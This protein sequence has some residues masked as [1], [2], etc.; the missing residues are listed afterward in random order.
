MQ[1]YCSFF[2]FLWHFFKQQFVFEYTLYMNYSKI[3]MDLQ[4]FINSQP[5]ARYC[6][7]IVCII[8]CRQYVT[9]CMLVAT[10]TG[11]SKY[12]QLSTY[13]FI[14]LYIH[15][16][17][18]SACAALRRCSET[19][20]PLYLVLFFFLFLFLSVPHTFL[21]EGF[22][23]GFRNF[24]WGFKSQKN[25]IWGKKKSGPPP[26]PL[27]GGLFYYFSLFFL[28]PPHTFLPE[29]SQIKFN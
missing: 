9:D 3:K 7:Y 15:W 10:F 25:K 23:V 28:S 6:I 11:K 21:P 12:S 1:F 14:Q 2:L 26:S 8:A 5:L 17:E 20:C 13:T 19:K 18:Q 24:A 29:I 16:S 4:L 27:G 22:I